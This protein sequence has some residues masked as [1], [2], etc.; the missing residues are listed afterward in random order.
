M[1]TSKRFYWFKLKEDFFQDKRIKKLRK[2]AGGDTYTIIYQKMMLKAIC[3]DGILEYEG[4][5]KT[6][7]DELALDLDEDK[8]N[9]AVTIDYL[10]RSGLME[11]ADETH[12]FMSKAPELTGSETSSAKR[13]RE[14]RERLKALQCNTGVTEVKQI[15]NTEIEIEKEID[16]EINKRERDKEKRAKRERFTPPTLEE[17]KAYAAEKGYKT[18]N[19]E[20][21]LGYYEANG[22]RVGKNPMKSWRAAVANWVAR[23]KEFNNPRSPTPLPGQ[24]QD[25]LDALLANGRI[26]RGINDKQQ[27]E[28][29][30]GGIRSG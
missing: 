10:L 13:V 11:N 28:G 1:A 21:F 16:I 26:G 17:L 6:F 2:I 20:R 14:H 15:C 27:E 4:I 24:R 9:V 25:D 18:F 30:T 5:E 29:Q 12:F 23:E 22:W 7:S 3:N 8:D 19:A